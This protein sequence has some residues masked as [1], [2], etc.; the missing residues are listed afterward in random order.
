M[1]CEVLWYSISK[2]HPC[3]FLCSFTARNHRN[4]LEKSTCNTYSRT[5]S[6]Q[7][8]IN[9]KIHS[10]NI[11]LRSLMF[12]SVTICHKYSIRITHFNQIVSQFRCPPVF[13]Y[14]FC[15]VITYILNEHLNSKHP[16]PYLFSTMSIKITEPE[17]CYD[18]HKYKLL[19]LVCKT[20]LLW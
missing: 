20:D 13:I 16:T 10:L 4:W 9:Y 19:A 8:K 14:V 6:T 3:L 2:V 5:Y 15:H 12:S 17:M 11:I 18:K 7:Y 1:L